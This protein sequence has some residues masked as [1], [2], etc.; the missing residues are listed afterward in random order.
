M[1]WTSRIW[2]T[3]RQKAELWER[4]NHGQCVSEI[5]RTPGGRNESGVYR[6]LALNDGIIPAPRRRALVALRLKESEEISRGIAARRS[7][8]RNTGDLGRSPSTVSREIRRNGGG[9][10]CRA[11]RADRRAW[12]QALRSSPGASCAATMACAPE[13][14]AAMVAGTDR[15]LA[16]A[17]V[18]DRAG[19]AAIAGKDLWQPPST[20]S[21]CGSLNIHERPPTFKPQPIDPKPCC[22]DSLNPPPIP[23]IFAAFRL[24]PHG[25]ELFSARHAGP[26]PTSADRDRGSRHCGTLPAHGCSRRRDALSARSLT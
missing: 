9:Q 25:I 3:P 8:R 16:E 20:E 11:N 12:D 22:T 10:G 1:K 6:I 5:A 19:H 23:A 7:T 4:W 13:A 21:P 24:M 15:R 26:S 14:C 2:F 18:P 17:A